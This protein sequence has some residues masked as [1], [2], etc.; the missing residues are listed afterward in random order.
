MTVEDLFMVEVPI[1]LQNVLRLGKERGFPRADL[2]YLVHCVL[3]EL[4]GEQAPKPFFIVSH[5]RQPARV[6]GYT[7]VSAKRMREHASVYAMPS[8]AQCCILDNLTSKSMPNEFGVGRVLG[9]QVQALPLVRITS[10]LSGWK[11]GAE[12]DVFLAHVKRAE[13]NE[14]PVLDRSLVY[15]EWLKRQ[16]EAGGACRLIHGEMAAFKL[17]EVLRRESV[18]SSSKNG[19]RVRSKRSFSRPEVLFQGELEVMNEDLFRQVIQRGIGRHRG[20][21]YGML[22][23]RPARK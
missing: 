7:R 2:G 1:N 8:V 19:T 6:I 13:L 21:G 15:I 3:G 5:D 12:V 9:F 23:L 10:P 16:L 11:P 17:K 20:F 14:V 4:F 22:L 18:D